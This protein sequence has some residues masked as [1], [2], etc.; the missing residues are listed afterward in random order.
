MGHN[1]MKKGD[2][3]K[4]IG[5]VCIELKNIKGIIVGR[6]PNN[7]TMWEVDFGNDYGKYDC[8]ESSLQKEITQL[9]FSFKD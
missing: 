6:S 1:Y 5:D 8:W 9:S 2:R 4:Y 7:N 3:V